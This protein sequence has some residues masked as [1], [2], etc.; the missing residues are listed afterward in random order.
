MDELVVKMLLLLE[1]SLFTFFMSLT[2]GKQMFRYVVCTLFSDQD[3][4]NN[5]FFGV[6]ILHPP[7]TFQGEGGYGNFLELHC[8]VCLIYSLQNYWFHP[9]FNWVFGVSTFRCKGC[10]QPLQISFVFNSALHP[11][12]LEVSS[13]RKRS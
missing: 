3:W 8:T 10:F 12:I 4:T 1:P 6:W 9:C 2:L 13:E 11:F 7:L 5:K